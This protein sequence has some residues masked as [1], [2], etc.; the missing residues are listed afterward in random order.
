M[1]ELPRNLCIDVQA[2][3]HLE[4]NKR[5]ENREDIFWRNKIKSYVKILKIFRN[6]DIYLN[7]R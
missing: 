3:M 6:N 1:K 4:I 7:E 5:W 2:L